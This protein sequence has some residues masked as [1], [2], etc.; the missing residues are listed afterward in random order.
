MSEVGY[1]EK[2]EPAGLNFFFFNSDFGGSSEENLYDGF[3]K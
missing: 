2:N 3:S 1:N